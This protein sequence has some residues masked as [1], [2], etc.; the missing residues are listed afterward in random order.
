MPDAER[1]IFWSDFEAPLELDRA[2]DCLRRSC[3]AA[4]WFSDRFLP[5]VQIGEVAPPGFVGRLEDKNPGVGV[6]LELVGPILNVLLAADEGVCPRRTNIEDARIWAQYLQH[7]GLL[8]NGWLHSRGVGVVWL[9]LCGV[10]DLARVA[11]QEVMVRLGSGRFHA[12]CSRDRFLC[13]GHCEAADKVG[14]TKRAKTQTLPKARAGQNQLNA[15]YRRRAD[16]G[17]RGAQNPHAGF[18]HLNRSDTRE[19]SR[20]PRAAL[21]TPPQLQKAASPDYARRAQKCPRRHR[22]TQQTPLR[23]F[24]NVT[25]ADR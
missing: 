19:T 3:R 7:C 22:V 4:G 24:S 13:F 14:Y 21:A 12:T 25:G 17:S 20:L 18:L 5:R 10:G 8:L 1:G 23:S 2:D 9:A 15:P 16:L 6:H 11:G